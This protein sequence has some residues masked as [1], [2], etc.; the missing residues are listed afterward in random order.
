MRREEELEIKIRGWSIIEESVTLTNEL[1][2]KICAI[3]GDVE[4]PS[5]VFSSSSGVTVA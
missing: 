4:R 3:K 5:G 2:R 1:R